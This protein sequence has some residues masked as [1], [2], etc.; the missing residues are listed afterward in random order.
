[1]GYILTAGMMWQPIRSGQDKIGH[2]NNRDLA[3]A[4]QLDVRQQ[5]DERTGTLKDK[6]SME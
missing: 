5:L 1:M 3:V 4:V 6:S 2:A